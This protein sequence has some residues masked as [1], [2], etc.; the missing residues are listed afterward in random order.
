MGLNE[1]CE[2]LIFALLGLMILAIGYIVVLNIF[3]SIRSEI[4]SN[5]AIRAYEARHNLSTR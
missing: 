4:A 3:D 5:R 1:I 2:I